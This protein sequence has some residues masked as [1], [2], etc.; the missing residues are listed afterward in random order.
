M[1]LR[2]GACWS[3]DEFRAVLTDIYCVQHR[4]LVGLAAIWLDAAGEEAVQAA[5]LDVWSRWER[6]R[7]ADKILLYLRR[8]VV[9]HALS[10]LRR[11]R[12][13]QR[14]F[15]PWSTDRLA[16]D[17]DGEPVRST[18]ATTTEDEA[19]GQVTD[20]AIV[21]CVRGLS[22]QQAACV[23]LRFYLGLSEKEIAAVRNISPG[24][25]KKHV[26]RAM[27]R[28]RPLLEGNVG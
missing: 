5:Y 6:I 19:L 7:D 27:I 20:D 17:D 3:Q 2:Q 10:E 23:G 1:G 4:K 15:P 24:A 18:S 22:R 14:A 13:A 25:V 16:S 26:S 9:N 28:L 21:L 12:V 8:A 11:R